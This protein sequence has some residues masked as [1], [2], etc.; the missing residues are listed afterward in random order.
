MTDR[1]RYATGTGRCA[2]LRYLT[3]HFGPTGYGNSPY[4]SLSSFAGNWLLIS[5]DGLALT[6]AGHVPTYIIRRGAVWSRLRAAVN[7]SIR[8]ARDRDATP[9]TA[10]VALDEDELEPAP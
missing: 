10:Y 4:Q 2:R 1:S 5:P 6:N 8:P 9:G 3:N 7:G